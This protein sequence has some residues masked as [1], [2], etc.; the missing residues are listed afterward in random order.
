MRELDKEVLAKIEK[1]G[2]KP[3]PYV[4][5]LAKRSVFWALAALSV[6]LGGVSVAVAIFA[7]TDLAATG[8]RGLDEM[9]FDDIATSL[10]ALW[11]ACFFLFAASAWF[12]LSRTRRGYRYR[13]LNILAVALAASLGLGAALHGLDAGRLA[14]NFIASRFPAY[15]R[16]THIPYDEWS[17]PDQGYLGGEVL[18]V[19]GGSLRLRAF[20]GVEWTVD[21]SAAVNSVDEPLEDEGDVAIR[22]ARTGPRAF[23]AQTIAAFD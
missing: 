5:F 20:G 2:L 4:Y 16:L 8:G 10:P 19:D 13:P 7:A 14:H 23:K 12:G 1:L 15:D 18:S 17:R 9:P 21:I 22:G 6:L 11:L 3:R